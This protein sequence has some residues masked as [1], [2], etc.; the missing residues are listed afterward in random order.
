MAHPWQTIQKAANTLI[1]GDTV[2]IRAGTYH[3][4]VTPQNSGSAGNMITY[5]AYPGETATIDGSGVTL[6]DDLAGLFDIS[7][8]SY[9]R[10]SGL[11]II[12]AG[13]YNN[14]AGI[15]VINSGYIT[16]ENNST[17]NTASSG[18]GAWGSQPSCS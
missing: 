6:P 18:I 16:V 14:N 13:P 2:Y 9:I 12:N 11:R 10:V 4:R 5:A 3:E 17:Y 1:A 7:N 15:L 8:M